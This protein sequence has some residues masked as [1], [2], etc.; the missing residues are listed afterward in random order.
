[1]QIY[2]D[3]T[4]REFA[5]AASPQVSALGAGMLAALAAG[6]AGGGYSSLDAAAQKMV[7]APSRVF[8]PNPQNK[9]VY[10]RLY[11]EY[12]RLCQYFSAENQVM[13]TLRSLRHS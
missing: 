13:K 10:D 5:V 9:A 2:A 4:G 7:P 8:L 3:I 1:M 12:I 11:A 6:E